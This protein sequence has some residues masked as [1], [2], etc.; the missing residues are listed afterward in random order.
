MNIDINK[1]AEQLC[2]KIVKSVY[3]YDTISAVNDY[4]ECEYNGLLFIIQYD[5]SCSKTREEPNYIDGM[6]ESWTGG[7]IVDMEVTL[8]DAGYYDTN[9]DWHELTVEQ[10]QA[11]EK[12]CVSSIGIIHTCCL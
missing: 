4:Y 2:D 9:D 12:V 11:I 6:I 1:F 7:E 10:K 5:W 8:N 3:D